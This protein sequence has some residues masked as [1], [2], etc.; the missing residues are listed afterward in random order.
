MSDLVPDDSD[1]FELQSTLSVSDAAT[2]LAKFEE[3]G[4]R[5]RLA[6]ERS[7]AEGTDAFTASQGGS[8]GAAEQIQIFTHRDDAEAAERI[9]RKFCGFE[10]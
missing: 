6:P 9:W 2:L 8:F 1:P 5:F 7:R 10:S 3:E 4:I